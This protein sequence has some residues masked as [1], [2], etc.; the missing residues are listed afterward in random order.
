MDRLQ[1]AVTFW[2]TNGDNGPAARQPQLTSS[3]HATSAR[4]GESPPHL[5][6]IKPVP[7]AK[8]T[9]HFDFFVIMVR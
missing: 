5:N 7:R 8:H 6:L 4:D 1:A 2:V 9:C 3:S